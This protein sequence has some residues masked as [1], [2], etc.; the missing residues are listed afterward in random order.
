MEEKLIEAVRVRK[1]LYDTSHKDYLKTK[2]KAEKWEEVA[3]ETDIR[4]GVEA[5]ALWEKLRH[6]LRDALRRQQKSIKSGALAE[7]LKEWK[8]QKQMGFLQPYM[9]SKTREGN[10][11]E[12]T[13]DNETTSKNCVTDSPTDVVDEGEESLNMQQVTRSIRDELQSWALPEMSPPPQ[14]P[15][16]AKK[17]K[18]A[19]F[20]GLLKRSIEQHEERRRWRSEE[21]RN[22]LAQT[23][24][25][26]DSLYHFF[27][28]MYQM[29]RCMPL[30]SQYVIRND[31]FRVVT[32]M[33]ASLLNIP[34]RTQQSN[35]VQLPSYHELSPYSNQSPRPP[36]SSS[37]TPSHSLHSNNPSLT[38][39]DASEFQKALKLRA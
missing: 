13:D 31:I 4:N 17:M 23:S 18:K 2:L 3:K 19:T 10:L 16:S 21:R 20:A 28:S 9:A 7:S 26:S 1:L 24:A 27:M 14:E 30:S 6:S 35:T 33:E 32:E 38:T 37:S 11:N 39:Q 15:T 8:F 22:L 5:K 12:Y 36:Y 34:V 25:P 29:T